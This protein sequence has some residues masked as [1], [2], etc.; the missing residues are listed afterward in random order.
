MMIELKLGSSSKEEKI[1]RDWD[2]V[3]LGSG[4]AGYTAGIY[5]MRGENRTLL[6]EGPS[7]GGLLSLSDRIENYPGFIEPI[8]GQKLIE[9]MKEQ[10]VKFGLKI[11]SGTATKVTRENSLFRIA[12]DNGDEFY[13]LALIVATG[14]EPKQLGIPGEQEFI[15]K[16]VSYCATC[17]APFFKDSIVTVIGG[18]DSAIKEA[19]FLTKFA[20]KVFVVHR[21]N[22][23]RAEKIIQ[24][25]AFSNP[26]IEFKLNKIPVEITGDKVVKKLIIKDTRTEAKEEIETEGV[27]IFIGYKPKTEFLSSIKVE[28]LL[29]DK[30]YIKTKED[31]STVI[32]GL[33]AAGDVREKTLRQVVTAAGDGATAAYSAQEYLIE[34][35]RKK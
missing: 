11:V 14:S 4:P 27:F 28:G 16:G 3:I 22:E 26:K 9:N 1:D 24:K 32:P 19:I 18:G 10:A 15:G 23:L 5:T 29:N 20:K 21:R 17:D 35:K 31:M 8:S 30:G 13:S 7:P 34:L 12:T 25:E 33:F 2:I 6:I